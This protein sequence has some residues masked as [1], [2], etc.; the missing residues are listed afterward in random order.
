MACPELVPYGD[1]HEINTLAVSS[2]TWQYAY[3]EFL[4]FQTAQRSD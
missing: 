3:L 2:R 4:I 1:I